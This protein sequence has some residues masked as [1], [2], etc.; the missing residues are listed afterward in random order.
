MDAITGRATSGSC[1]LCKTLLQRAWTLNRYPEFKDAEAEDGG[2][3]K[4]LD[5]VCRGVANSPELLHRSLFYHFYP[6]YFL[7][8]TA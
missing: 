5:A 4:F 1:H 7:R 6:P 3:G 2:R 8:W